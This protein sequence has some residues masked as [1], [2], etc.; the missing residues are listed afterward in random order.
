MPWRDADMDR[1]IGRLLQT[2]VLIAGAVV[3]LG[4]ILYLL[5]HGGEVPDYRHF[6]GVPF[7]LGG[8]REFRARSVIQLGVVLMI[9]TPVLRVAF[10]VVAFARER[11]WLYAA[12]SSIVLGVLMFGIFGSH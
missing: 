3:L 7:G 10:C 9:A 11:D 6:H 4:G 12:I 5:G 1:V 8:L 2:G